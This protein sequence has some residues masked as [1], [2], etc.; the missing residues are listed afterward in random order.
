[1]KGLFA[2]AE[3]SVVVTTPGESISRWSQPS[4]EF[5]PGGHNPAGSSSLV[6]T[7]QRGVPPWWSQPRAKV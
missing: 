1:M 2:P 5:L 7:T 6:V 3:T 4:G